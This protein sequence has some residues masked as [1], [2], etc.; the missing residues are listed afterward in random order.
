MLLFPT[1]SECQTQAFLGFG[2]GLFFYSPGCDRVLLS[3]SRGGGGGEGQIGKGGSVW[4][5]PCP[6]YIAKF[7][8]YDLITQNPRPGYSAKPRLWIL[9][10]VNSEYPIYY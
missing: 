9:K 6:I 7:C 1:H 4:S 10:R 2:H 3:T 5:W 8:F